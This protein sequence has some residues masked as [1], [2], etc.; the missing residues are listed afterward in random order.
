MGIESDMLPDNPAARLQSFLDRMLEIEHNDKEQISAVFARLLDVKNSPAEIFPHYSQLFVLIEEAFKKVMQY[1]PKQQK[2]HAAWRGYLTTT[3]QKHSPYHHEWKALTS[4]LRQGTHLDIIQ[5]A[6]D[7][8]EHFVKPTKVH[9]L[10]VEELESEV[11]RLIEDIKTSSELSDYLKSFLK[12]ELEK[13]LDRIK[14]FDLY[15]SEPIRKSIYN[16]IANSEVSKKSA[17]K[18]IAGVSA[19]LVSVASAIG[20]VNDVASFPQ[21]LEDLRSEFLQPYIEESKESP[22]LPEQKINEAIELESEK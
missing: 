14:H 20:V 12:E 2:T 8:L 10:T 18:A 7:N 4:A 21:S 19:F 11:A 17:T 3:L 22:A 5:V 9:G 16:I 6:N 15:G 1:Y 13:I